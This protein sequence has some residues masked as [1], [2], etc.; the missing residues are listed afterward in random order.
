MRGRERRYVGLLSSSEGVRNTLYLPRPLGGY[1][2]AELAAAQLGMRCQPGLG[3]ERNA[4][5]LLNGDHLERV[6]AL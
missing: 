2:E 5:P 6:A 4:P 1:V 3:C